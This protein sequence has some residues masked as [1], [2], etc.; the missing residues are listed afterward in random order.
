MA[1]DLGFAVE[2]V[3]QEAYWQTTAL[4]ILAEKYGFDYCWITDHFNNRS[5][6]IILSLLAN[7][8]DQI[9]IGPGV[10]NPYLINPV[11]TASTLMSLDNLSGGRT[12]LGIGAG[13]KITLNLLGIERDKPLTAVKESVQIFRALF[14][15]G[16]IKGFKG[17][18]FTVETAKIAFEKT[19][20]LPIYIGAQGPKMLQ[21][22]G[23]MGQGVLV[24]ASHPRDF[25]FA[26]KQIEKGMKEAKRKP[27]DVDIAAY[28]SVSVDQKMD[29]ATKAAIPVVAFIVAGS[30]PVVLDRH[31]IALKS[32]KP[33]SEALEKGDFPTA[34]GAV[35]DEMLD[36]FCIRGTPSECT[37]KIAGLQ[38]A[39]ITQFVFGSPIG[40][41]KRISMELASK[42]ILPHF[43]S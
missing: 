19:G 21:L 17:E 18:I 9:K 42:E 20:A 40:P 3:P 24:N 23:S 16:K 7:Y 43:R 38:K 28:A 35:T 32:V 6:Y 34:F 39:G 29:K 31:N 14:D 30:P 22:A 27:G 10:T 37:E 4:G 13:D 15:T 1:P 8:T 11:Q 5:V 36:V 41:K 25:E 33:I 12:I 26:S 2:F